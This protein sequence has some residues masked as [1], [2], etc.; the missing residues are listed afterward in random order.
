MTKA[1]SYLIA[2]IVALSLLASA[3]PTLAKLTHLAAY[4]VIVVGIVTVVLRLVWYFTD[5]Y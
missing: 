1:L 5:R 4:L 3:T 2:A